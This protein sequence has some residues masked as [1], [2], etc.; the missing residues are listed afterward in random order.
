MKHFIASL[1]FVIV[2]SGGS[3]LA[4]TNEFYITDES[5]FSYGDTVGFTQEQIDRAR[6]AKDS[7]PADK[8][9]EGNWGAVTEG[10]QLS[11]RL[12]KS[13]FTNGEPI[14]ACVILRNVSSRRL[15]FGV[16]IPDDILTHF[17]LK[18]DHGFLV[19][20][21]G[22]EGTNFAARLSRAHAG[23]QAFWP[24]PEGTQRKFNYDLNQKF[25]L[26]SNGVYL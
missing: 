26:S 21:T 7:R 18:T 19:P 24:S 3:L 25:N 14:T 12:P 1:S 6:Q 22:I 13:S 16:T 11:V 9:P 5:R 8:D 10:F 20:E 17:T 4:Q 23:S 2:S 15:R